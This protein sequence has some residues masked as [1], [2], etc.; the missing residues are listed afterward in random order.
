MKYFISCDW[1]TSR[2]RLRL[3][4][5]DSLQIIGEVISEDG[6]A[7]TF[8]NWKFNNEKID[9]VQF[10]AKIIFQ[11]YKTRPWVLLT[12]LTDICCRNLMTT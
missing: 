10:F 11:C 9:R 1:G 8:N 2:M 3:V 6:I 5:K 7:I 12:D 4:K